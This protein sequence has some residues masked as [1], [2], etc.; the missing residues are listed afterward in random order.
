MVQRMNKFIL[1][2]EMFMKEEI[3]TAYT[4]ASKGFRNITGLEVPASW[5]DSFKKRAICNNKLLPLS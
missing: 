3:Q 2:P 1:L 5:R 4:T